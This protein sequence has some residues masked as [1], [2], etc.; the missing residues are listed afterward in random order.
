M[1]FLALGQQVL[2]GQRESGHQMVELGL[3]PGLFVMA[4]FAFLALLPLM[5]VVLLVA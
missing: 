1:A 3:L 2:P 4:G 5:L